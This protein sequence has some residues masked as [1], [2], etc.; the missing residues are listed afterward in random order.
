M[1]L[2]CLTILLIYGG[3]LFSNHPLTAIVPET[4]HVAAGICFQAVNSYSFCRCHYSISAGIA[5]YH[6]EANSIFSQVHT[7]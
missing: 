1:V 2:S 4:E 7:F 3:L 6:I 5:L